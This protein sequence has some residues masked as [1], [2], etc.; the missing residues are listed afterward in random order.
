MVIINQI[1]YHT[2]CFVIPNAILHVSLA[3]L[4]L[5]TRQFATRKLYIPFLPTLLSIPTFAS[6]SGYTYSWWTYLSPSNLLKNHSY[7]Y[8]ECA[9]CTFVPY[10]C[11]EIPRT[12]RGL[13]SHVICIIYYL[14]TW[15]MKVQQIW[16]SPVFYTLLPCDRDDGFWR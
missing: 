2:L 16:I 11:T 14:A 7:I 15:R 6:V 3:Y 4:L 10:L 1:L 12:Q 13:V 8:M 9:A 5:L